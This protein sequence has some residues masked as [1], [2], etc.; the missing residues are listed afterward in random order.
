MSINL[1]AGHYQIDPAHSRVGFS[2]RHALVTRVRG[3]FDV[4]GSATFDP[5]HPEVNRVEVTLDV[6]SIDTRNADR[7]A[8]LR[9]GDFFDVERFPV[10]NFSAR[11]VALSGAGVSLAGDLLVKGVAHPVSFD[12]T[13]HGWSVDP[14]GQERHGFEGEFVVDRRQ[15]GLTWNVA[16][17]AGGLLVSE[18]VTLEF[19][20]SAIRHDLTDDASAPSSD[21][22]PSADSLAA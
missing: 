19:E 22:T 18:K 7:D 3:A 8:H 10:M 14:Y 16:L 1:P 11:D 4:V 17:E 9:S 20:I 21:A 15:L 2:A 6:D 13:Y 5:A 12:L